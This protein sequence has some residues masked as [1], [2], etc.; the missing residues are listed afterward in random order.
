MFSEK[1]H[2]LHFRIIFPW[3]KEGRIYSLSPES[4]LRGRMCIWCWAGPAGSIDKEPLGTEAGRC[5]E[6]TKVIRALVGLTV[7]TGARSRWVWRMGGS[8]HVSDARVFFHR[9][10]GMGAWE[11]LAGIKPGPSAMKTPSPNHWT[12]REFPHCLL[13]ICITF[14]RLS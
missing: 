10:R 2:N 11:S 5:C 1:L 12:A 13:E 6:G 7:G 4:H 9:H 8:T 14:W 3:Q